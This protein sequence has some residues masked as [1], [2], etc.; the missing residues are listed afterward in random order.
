MRRVR[1]RSPLARF[2]QFSLSQLKSSATL[3]V[4]E[5][6]I[7][8]DGFRRRQPL[9]SLSVFRGR[10]DFVFF[11]HD[12]FTR[13]IKSLTLRLE[14]PGIA[15]EFSWRFA[16]ENPDGAQIAA[17]ETAAAR[18]RGT[19]LHIEVPLGEVA[20]LVEP[21]GVVEAGNLQAARA[22]LHRMGPQ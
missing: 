22:P 9:A 13:D 6:G 4:G 20:G 7:R 1:A 12:L 17:I 2:R 15:F 19:V 11:S 5:A 3:P 16:E 10:G 8:D 14:R 21:Q 18:G